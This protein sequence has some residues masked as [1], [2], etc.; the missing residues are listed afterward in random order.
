LSGGNKR[1]LSVAMAIAGGPILSVFDEPSAGLDPIA[2]HRLWGV[3]KL[4]A[5]SQSRSVLITTHLMEEAEALAHKIGIMV[6]GQIRATGSPQAL[7][8]ELG[9]F[10]E[11]TMVVPTLPE[12]V[13]SF[14]ADCFL[15]LGHSG[16]TPRGFVHIKDAESLIQA[17]CS[18]KLLK[19]FRETF[20][21][22]FEQKAIHP[23]QLSR[24][25]NLALS[26]EVVV[27]WV[28][29]SF[30]G[31]R[32]LVHQ[33]DGILKWKLS[34]FGSVVDLFKILETGKKCGIIKQYSICQPSLDQ[35]F[36]RVADMTR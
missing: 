14:G 32:N 9:G 11:V 18:E 3:V 30:T 16:D 34:N 2:R 24:W 19:S 10:F 15:E 17:T 7:K 12:D 28:N 31:K 1:R 27:D 20:L 13:N 33:S 22:G 29:G 4:L 25:K 6:D 8:T 26:T 23:I 36:T 5:E 35:V 21:A